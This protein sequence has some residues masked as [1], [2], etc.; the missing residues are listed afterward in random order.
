MAARKFDPPPPIPP[1]AE[2]PCDWADELA[3]LHDVLKPV[4]ERLEK[5][6]CPPEC[7]PSPYAIVHRLLAMVDGDALADWVRAYAS[8]MRG[9]GAPSWRS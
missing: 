6:G 5:A 8:V 4:Y 1:A 7:Y 9:D 3:P 2:D